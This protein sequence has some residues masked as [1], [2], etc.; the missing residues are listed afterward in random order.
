MT[1]RLT[2]TIFDCSGVFS[3]ASSMPER[4]RLFRLFNSHRELTERFMADPSMM[5]LFDTFG[6]ELIYNSLTSGFLHR[7]VKFD[8]VH[9]CGCFATITALARSP[10]GSK[11]YFSYSP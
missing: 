11:P 7:I 8:Q 6:I 2:V 3:P 1:F 10:S 9:T 5:G 4:T